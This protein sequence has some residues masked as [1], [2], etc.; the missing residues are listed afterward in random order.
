MTP[1]GPLNSR[2]R[3]SA[4]GRNNLMPQSGASLSK[5]R[6]R[7]RAMFSAIAPTYDFLNHWLSLNVD[8]WWRR[9]A[10]AA[11]AR[12]MDESRAAASHNIQLNEFPPAAGR[13]AAPQGKSSP[14]PLILDLAAG[15]GDL[16]LEV[17]RYFEEKHREIPT[18]AGVDFAHPMLTR[19]C[20][21]TR[22]AGLAGSIHFAEGDGC[23][24][25][26]AS[27]VFDAATIAFGLRNAEDPHAMLAEFARVLRPGGVLAILEFSRPAHPLHRLIFDFYFFYALPLAGALIS[28]TSAYSYLPHSVKAFWNSRETRQALRRAGLNPLSAW[29][30]SGGVA[31]LHLARKPFSNQLV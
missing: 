1:A 26:L 22:R 25:P 13:D 27:G 8:R 16:T 14:G 12:A 10:A 20:E 2:R 7:I 21:K 30:L 28:R 31:E 29:R 17:A 11:L 24:L 18:I 4:V 23:R 6:P 3:A 5:S 15:T 9:E 19:A